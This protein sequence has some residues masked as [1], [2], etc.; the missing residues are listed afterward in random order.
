L[1]KLISTEEV[2]CTVPSPS[3]RIPWIDFRLIV[4]A[5]LFSL[6]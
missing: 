5:M 1:I 2:N 6:I 3:L 4:K